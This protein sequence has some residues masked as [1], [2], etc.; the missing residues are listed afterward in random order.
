[1]LDQK[2]RTKSTQKWKK[3][4][5]GLIRP[6]HYQGPSQSARTSLCARRTPLKKHPLPS[7]RRPPGLWFEGVCLN[8]RHPDP[9]RVWQGGSELQLMTP[10]MTGSGG[11]GGSPGML[12]MPGEFP[13]RRSCCYTR[14]LRARDPPET[15][16]NPPLAQVQPRVPQNASK[17]IKNT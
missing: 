12:G 8:S 6:I 14:Y 3:G 5:R 11:S 7:S 4:V 16:P 17:Y 1:M 13:K 10:F 2:S 9:W 15:G